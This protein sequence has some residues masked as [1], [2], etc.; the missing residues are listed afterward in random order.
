MSEKH[1]PGFARVEKWHASIAHIRSGMSTPDGN[2]WTYSGWQGFRSEAD[3]RE[4]VRRWNAHEQLYA[5]CKAIVAAQSGDV[6]D[7]IAAMD[8]AA[9][10]IAAACPDDTAEHVAL[11]PTHDTGGEG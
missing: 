9:A 7:V 3:A 4:F 5:A 10:A 2:D 6:G 8:M 1:T 11:P